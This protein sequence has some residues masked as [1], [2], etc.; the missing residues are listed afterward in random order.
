MD[1]RTR[2]YLEIRLH[3][4]AYAVPVELVRK[5]D[6]LGDITPLP[7]SGPHV[8]GLM[9]LRGQVLPVIDL[10]VRLGL[11]R[12][13]TTRATCVLVVEGMEGTVGL[14][15]DSVARVISIDEEMLLPTPDSI[16]LQ[17]HSLISGIAKE[18]TRMITLLSIQH[19]LDA[20]TTAHSISQRAMTLLD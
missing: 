11:V 15:V 17:D 7:N 18:G 20:P 10:N 19:C 13:Q 5:I 1:S 16:H 6:Q 2:S 3:E 14:L 4:Q 12:N 8:C 9:N